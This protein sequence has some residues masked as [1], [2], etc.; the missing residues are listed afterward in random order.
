M[1]LENP[2]QEIRDHSII[3]NHSRFPAPWQCFSSVHLILFLK[4][5]GQ[6]TETAIAEAWFCAQW[7][8]FVL[9]LRFVFGLLDGWKIQTWPIRRFLTESITCWFFICWFFFCNSPAVV[10]GVFSHS[11]SPPNRALGRYRHTSSSRQ[12]QNI[13]CWLEILNYCPDGGNGNLHGS[14]SFLKTTSLIC[15][16]QLSFAAHHKYIL[17]FFSLWWMINLEF[18]LCFPSFIFLWNSKPWLDKFMFKIV[19]MNGNI[20]QI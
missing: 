11:N 16:A 5:S 3:Q 1:R 14:S 4:G 12:F 18:G 19:N 6:G 8:I 10:F 13:F 2:W 15:E 17:C 7:P 9:F 20:L